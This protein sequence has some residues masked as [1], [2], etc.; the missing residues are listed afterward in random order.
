MKQLTPY[1]KKRFLREHLRHRLTLL[2]TLRQRTNANYNFQKQ[3]DMY[4]CVKDSNLIAVRLLLDFL[5]LKGE[6]HKGRFRLKHAGRKNG[7]KW[8]DD[9]KVDQFFRRL[10]TPKDVPAGS[11]ELL[12]GVYVR[13]DKELAH[14]TLKFNKRFNEPKALIDAATAVES[15]IQK[16]VY[17]GK[18]LPPMD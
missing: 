18:P 11:R 16:F 4:R 7:Q 2:R 5:G 14:L 12:A 9:V 6:R 17:R 8:Q 15:L 13:A 10:L 1:T 3:G